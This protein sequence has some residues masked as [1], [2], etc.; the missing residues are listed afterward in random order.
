MISNN[1]NDTHISRYETQ[2]RNVS[3]EWS[4]KGLKENGKREKLHSMVIL[5]K[6][7]PE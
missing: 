2:E 1:I 4:L 5:T 6:N 3:N 7:L